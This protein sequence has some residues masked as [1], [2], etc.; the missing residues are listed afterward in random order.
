MLLKNLKKSIEG[1]RNENGFMRKAMIG[2]IAINAIL[3]VSLLN[4]NTLVTVVPPAMT[5]QG[6]VDSNAASDSFTNAWALYVANVVGNVTPSTAGI[7]RSSLEPLLDEEIYQDVIN[8]IESQVTK[9][10]QDRVTLKFEPKKVL[11]EKE[12]SNK[13]YVTGR[14]IMTG[15]TGKPERTNVT[16]EIILEIHNYRPVIKYLTTYNGG[17]KTEDVI[18]REEK[19]SKAKARMEKANESK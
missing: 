10:R 15:P 18:R 5:E 19:S 6:W 7:I 8:S 9:I 13:F 16:Y 12:D 1:T 14:S 2:M 17:P 11:R 4:R 3:V